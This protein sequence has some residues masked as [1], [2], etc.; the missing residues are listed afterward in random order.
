MKQNSWSVLS[1]LRLQG[2]FS[3]VHDRKLSGGCRSCF[4]EVNWGP[5]SV[6]GERWE[7]QVGGGT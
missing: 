2:V 7:R 4:I 6:K 3:D 1:V 5:V